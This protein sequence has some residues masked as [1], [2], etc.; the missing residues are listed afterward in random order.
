[1]SEYIIIKCMGCGKLF[2]I[3]NGEVYKGDSNYCRECNEKSKE[4]FEYKTT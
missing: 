2:R 4:E 1:M 3:Y